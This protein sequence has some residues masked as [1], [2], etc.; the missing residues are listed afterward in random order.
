MTDARKYFDGVQLERFRRDGYLAVPGRFAPGLSRIEAWS[1]EVAAMPQVP[2]LTGNP[3]RV[4]YVTLNRLSAG[5]HR[6]RCYADKRF[7]YP[8]DCERE[9]H[10][11]HAFRV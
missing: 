11:H 9:P 4:L 7:S 3:R 10:R 6:T 1:R 2:G 8:P 5:N